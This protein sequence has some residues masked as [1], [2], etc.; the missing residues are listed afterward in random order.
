MPQ[1]NTQPVPDYFRATTQEGHVVVCHRLE[2]NLV[3]VY[4]PLGPKPKVKVTTAEAREHLKP[5]RRPN[6]RLVECKPLD[7]EA[8]LLTPPM[9]E[10]AHTA[11]K[12]LAADDPDLASSQNGVGFS[13]FD[14]EVGHSLAERTTLTRRQAA[15]ARRLARKYRRQL[16]DGLLETLKLAGD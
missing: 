1:P 15:L 6:G 4:D 16:P 14:V 2:G 8:E 13:K 3:E 7:L 11:M 5:V 12:I 10:A 9:V